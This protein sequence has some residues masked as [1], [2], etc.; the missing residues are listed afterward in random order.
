MEA[1]AVGCVVGLAACFVRRWTW[2]VTLG[3]FASIKGDDAESV[4]PVTVDRLAAGLVAS[5]MIGVGVLPYVEI[6]EKDLSQWIVALLAGG[7]WLAWDQLSL[8]GQL[9]FKGDL[10]QVDAGKRSMGL[11]PYLAILLT[12][13]PLL[14][15]PSVFMV[16]PKT[17][18]DVLAMWPSWVLAVLKIPVLG[19]GMGL[20]MIYQGLLQF[21]LGAVALFRLVGTLKRNP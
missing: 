12:V 9:A 2:D 4:W 3:I 20:M 6:Q 13:G 15:G 21:P 17:V 19:W 8:W 5:I 16:A 11:W 1:A 14:V 18:S 7:L 10:G